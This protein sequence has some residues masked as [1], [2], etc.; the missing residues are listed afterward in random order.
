M[1]GEHFGEG[2]AGGQQVL[3]I[4]NDQE[5]PLVLEK[6]S[7]SLV[8]RLSGQGGHSQRLGNGDRHKVGIAERRQRNEDDPVIKRVCNPRGHFDRQPGFTD[9]A[10]SG[11]GHQPDTVGPATFTYRLDI[12]CAA[13]ELRERA[14]PARDRIGRRYPAKRRRVPKTGYG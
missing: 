7:Q 8:E 4:V 12:V 13:D 11:D 5:Q 1:L 2:W 3:H 6:R 10:R 9:A 14:G